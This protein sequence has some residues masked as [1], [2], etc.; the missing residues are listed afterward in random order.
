MIRA[1]A[2]KLLPEKYRRLRYEW[3]ETLRYY[4]EL[5]LSLGRR[6][7]CPFCGWRFRRLRSAGFDYPVLKEQRV[8]GAS[9]HPDDVCPRC[10]SNARER[11]LYLYLKN[12][13]PVFTERLRLLHIAPEPHLA[14]RLRDVGRIDYVTGDLMEQGVD[15]TLDVMMLP[16]PDDSFDLV[17][18]NH[19]LEHVGDDRVAM[20]ELHRVLRPG[21]PAL[22]Q[23]PIAMALEETLEDPTA[24][25]EAER[26]RLFGQRDHVRL[27]AAGDYM[28]RL[29]GVG[30]R[31]SLS[32][33]VDCL[34][35]AA[36]ARYALLRDEPVFFCRSSGEMKVDGRPILGGYR[37][38]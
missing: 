7:E 17:I 37:S 18:C 10:M 22:L 13:T 35:E 32:R 30:F 29:E 38:D 5:V 20:S 16:F 24:V 9:C 8:V 3:A 14:Q 34:G 31:V 36:V 6:L 33:A 27:Y 11:F 15:V 19:V 12:K 25:T 28:R 26:I 1:W 4:P 2:K 23:V 21:R